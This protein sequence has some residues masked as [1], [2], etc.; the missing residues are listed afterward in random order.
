[1]DGVIIDSEPL[2]EQAFRDVFDDLGYGRLTAC[3]SPIT[4]DVPTRPCGRISSNRHRPPQ[5]FEFLDGR[6]N[7][8]A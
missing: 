1:M 2:H 7:G 8:C 3:I 5:P 6:P 4:T